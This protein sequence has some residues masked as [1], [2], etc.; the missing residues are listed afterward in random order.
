LANNL[1]ALDVSTHWVAKHILEAWWGGPVGARNV[2][3][4]WNGRAGNAGRQ[5]LSQARRWAATITASTY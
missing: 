3:R 5:P 1:M 4:L 2:P